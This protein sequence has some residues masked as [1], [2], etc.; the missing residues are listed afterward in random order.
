MIPRECYGCR[1]L[2]Q[3]GSGLNVCLRFDHDGEMQG[4]ILRDDPP[5][6]LYP[7][8]YGP[9][10]SAPHLKPQIVRAVQA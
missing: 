6:P 1:H 7:D 5:E 8:C 3:G 4:T 9:F 10:V 2:L